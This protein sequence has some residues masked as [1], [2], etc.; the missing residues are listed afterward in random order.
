MSRGVIN[1]LTYKDFLGGFATLDVPVGYNRVQFNQFTAGAVDNFGV[2]GGNERLWLN[3]DE[4]KN[5]REPYGKVLTVKQECPYEMNFARN[6]EMSV[7]LKVFCDGIDA[8]GKIVA[9][10]AT[11]TTIQLGMN[12]NPYKITDR[13]LKIY[14]TNE[15]DL[16]VNNVGIILQLTFI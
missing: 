2:I 14:I 4:T 6:P 9:A 10:C 8:Q 7:V 12:G 3:L 16:I 5:V 11:G 15:V 13:T 1:T